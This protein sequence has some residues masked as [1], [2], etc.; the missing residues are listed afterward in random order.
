MGVLPRQQISGS[1]SSTTRCVS[2]HRLAEQDIVGSVARVQS[3]GNGRRAGP[4]TNRRLEEALNALLEEVRAN[5]QQI[6]ESD[7]EDI[8]Q[9][10]GRQTDRQSGPAGQKLHTGRSRNDQVATDLKLWVKIPLANCWRL[11]VSCRARWWRPHKTIR[12]RWCRVI[13]HLQRAAAGDVRALVSGLCWDAGAWRKPFAG[14]AEASGRQPARL[15]RA[16]GTAMKSTV[17]SWQAGW[18][19]PQRPANSPDSVVDRDHV[20]ELLS[21]AAIG[22]VHLVALCWR[23]DFL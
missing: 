14:C 6:L 19:L 22:M 2:D 4:Q 12:T 8:P 18:A 13:I 20:L 3:A 11:T 21:N 9:L 10:G 5:P 15:W 23:P 7:A 17:N 16:G 1:N